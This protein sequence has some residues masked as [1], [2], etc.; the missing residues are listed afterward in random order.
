MS[1]KLHPEF[2]DLS[3]PTGTSDLL[4]LGFLAVMALCCLGVLIYV[5][6]SRRK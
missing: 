6:I 4:A 2:T 1:K 5:F 3:I